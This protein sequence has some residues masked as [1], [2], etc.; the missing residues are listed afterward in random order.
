[1]TPGELIAAVVGAITIVSF[2][3][4]GYYIIK[5]VQARNTTVELT[6]KDATINTYKQTQDAMEARIEQLETTAGEL[7][8]ENA[9]LRGKILVLEQYAAPE[10]VARMEST[11]EVIIKILESIQQELT[12]D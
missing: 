12:K 5:N 3:G 4:V 7:K 9:E 2:F 1:M 10:L 8:A 11:Q 6:A